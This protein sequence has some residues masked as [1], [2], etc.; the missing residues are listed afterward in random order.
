MRKRLSQE[1]SPPYH[2]FLRNKRVTIKTGFYR[3]KSTK[4]PAGQIV[5]LQ[6]SAFCRPMATCFYLEF[7]LIYWTSTKRGAAVGFGVLILISR[8]T[9]SR[10]LETFSQ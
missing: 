4:L 3:I 10:P 6:P 9:T 2:Y 5:S 7:T 1:H 8:M